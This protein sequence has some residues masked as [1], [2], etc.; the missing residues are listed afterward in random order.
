V[1]GHA[2]AGMGSAVGRGSST[3]STGTPG[4]TRSARPVEVI[5]SAGV[6]F[7][8]INATRAAGVPG[9]TGTYAAPA[10][11]TASAAT[12]MSADRSSRTPTGAVVS[13]VWTMPAR[14]A[15]RSSRSR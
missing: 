2:V 15:T 11:F 14:S 9:S 6:A 8:R 1:A 7:S 5:T 12:T 3:S 4:G 10:R 13:N